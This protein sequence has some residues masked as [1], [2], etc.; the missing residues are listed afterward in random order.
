[1]LINEIMDFYIQYQLKQIC[2]KYLAIVSIKSLAVE[3]DSYKA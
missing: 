3:L 2:I 1:M